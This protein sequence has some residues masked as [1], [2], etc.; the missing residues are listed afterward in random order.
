MRETILTGSELNEDRDIENSL[1]P[2]RFEDFVGQEKLI[3]NLKV[4][5]QSARM[6]NESLD[7]TILHGPPGL[8]KTTLAHLIANELGVDIK[9]TSGPVLEKAADLA[10]LLTN[11]K[12][13]DVIFI[14][15]IHRLSPVIEEYLY[16]AME[17]YT[18]DIMLSSGP[19]AN[20]VQLQLP[21]FTL[22]GA[23]T[24]AGNLTSPLR[25]RF[26]VS[27][28]MNYYESQDIYKILRRSSKILGIELDDEAAS[29]MATR[30]RGTPR[31]AIRLL[32]RIRDFAL[33]RHS[34]IIS[35]TIAVSALESLDI[36]EKGLD[37]MDRAII[38][39]M[40]EKFNGGPVGIKNISVAVGEESDTIEEVY[41]PFLIQEGFIQRT[42][43]GRIVTELG[44]KHYGKNYV[45]NNLGL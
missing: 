11:L 7:H 21:K 40:I 9:V 38:L 15:E 16:P 29:E 45:N 35:K 17:D 14:D 3:E 30:S 19:S 12:E 24:R 34:G 1:R 18:I 2:L 26:G 5:V 36:D 27:C 43:R 39:A 37:D 10:G 33:V 25:A 44:Y 8:G 13:R 20:S 4:F 23:T 22:I 41:E 42:Q 31:I 32:R 28:R 6:R